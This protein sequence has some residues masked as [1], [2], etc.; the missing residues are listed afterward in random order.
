MIFQ[1]EY[2]S[3]IISSYLGGVSYIQDILVPG[4]NYANINKTWTRIRKN[5]VEDLEKHSLYCTHNTCPLCF[6]I[7]NVLKSSIVPINFAIRI[8]RDPYK[9]RS[10]FS[11]IGH[12][13]AASGIID[14]SISRIR[15]DVVIS[16]LGIVIVLAEIYIIF[17]ILSDLTKMIYFF[18]APLKLTEDQKNKNEKRK[19]YQ[20]TRRLLL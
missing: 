4:D 3:S 17:V 14:E 16:L 6:L 5:Y 18:F 20:R 13:E 10:L 11:R 12:N 2:V 8:G 19:Y 7:P 15:R 1:E 9:Y